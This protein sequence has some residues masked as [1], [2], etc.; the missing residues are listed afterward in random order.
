MGN[1]LVARW[2]LLIIKSSFDFLPYYVQNVEILSDLLS[3]LARCW[4][5]SSGR[6]VYWMGM[7]V[8]GHLCVFGSKMIRGCGLQWSLSIS[9]SPTPFPLPPLSIL[10]AVSCCLFLTGFGKTAYMSLG[11]HGLVGKKRVP[12]FLSLSHSFSHHAHCVSVTQSIS[13]SLT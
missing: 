4:Y 11:S 12:I 10:G 6:F 1:L 8:C 5:H 9:R 3:S 2:S 7:C 13:H